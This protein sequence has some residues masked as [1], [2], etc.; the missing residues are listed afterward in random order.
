MNGFTGA[1]LAVALLQSEP[2][3][4]PAREVEPA[5]AAAA[6]GE[7]SPRTP[8]STPSATPTSTPA[9]T[10]PTSN[11]A[12]TPTRTT[13]PTSNPTPTRTTPT[14]NPTSNPTPT[15]T[16]TATAA[17]TPTPTPTATAAPTAPAP[18]PRGDAGERAEAERVAR[19][20]LDALAASD[21]DGLAASAA[22]RFSFDGDPYAGRDAIR[23]RWRALLA[24][25]SGPPPRVGA[26][27]V[28]P[29]ADAVARLGKPPARVAPLA[30]PGAWVV[31]ADVGGRGVVLFV[32][33]EAGRVAVL[34]V[35]D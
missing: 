7:A 3:A 10:T 22:D 6:P 32:A 1:V 19:A 35:H 12:P 5:P 26:V 29:A 25:R 33:R 30:R 17:P 4:A 21:A 34:G 23:A 24:G 28:L 16:A 2:A 27:E 15:A 14:S 31:L 9:R 13:T 18:R 20:F 8:T 11:P